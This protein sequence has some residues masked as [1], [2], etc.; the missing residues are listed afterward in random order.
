M[1]ILV[2]TECDNGI[3]KKTA[4]EAVSY[5]KGLADALNTTVTAV[6]INGKDTEQLGKYGADKVLDVSNDALKTFK[7][8]AYAE[9][10][11]QAAKKE[12]TRVIII[13]YK[14]N[15]KYLAP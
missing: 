1:S 3:F 4:F 11:T 12:E 14:T 5:A 8:D 6:S 2:Y 7:A 13:R 9:A 10:I 15:S